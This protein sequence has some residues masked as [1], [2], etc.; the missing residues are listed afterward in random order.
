MRSRKSMVAAGAALLTVAAIAATAAGSVSATPSADYV[1]DC[2]ADDPDGYATDGRDERTI[3]IAD[4]Q[5]VTIFVSGCDWYYTSGEITP[6]GAGVYISGTTELFTVTGAANLNTYV[7]GLHGFV[8]SFQ[9]PPPPTTTVV[10]TTTTTVVETTTTV[11]T[12]GA[13]G[14]TQDAVVV[15]GQL[16]VSGENWAPRTEVDVELRSDPVA[17]GTVTTRRDGTFAQTFTLP[18]GVAPGAHEVHLTGIDASG[19]PARVVLDV[20]IEAV[21]A[22][23]TVPV[24]T[25]ASVAAPALPATGNAATGGSVVAL[26]V[27]VG[28][29]LLV[30]AA[31]RPTRQD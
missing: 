28:G 4:D 31:R 9:T 26:L 23:T 12:A 7:A 11:V 2:T 30:S 1:I 29:A 27:L 8:W 16:R 24:A 25:T 18:E 5:T 22:A 21:P 17:L 15:G 14:S 19:E 20:T 10:E 6:V 13:S 3:D